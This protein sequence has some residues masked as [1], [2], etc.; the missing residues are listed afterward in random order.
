MMTKTYDNKELRALWRL[1]MMP[2]TLEVFV[3]FSG[4][5]NEPTSNNLQIFM[6]EKLLVWAQLDLLSSS[7]SA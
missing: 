2:L 4:L 1:C 7:F 3:L 5:Q 6:A